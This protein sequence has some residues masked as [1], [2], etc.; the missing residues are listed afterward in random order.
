VSQDALKALRRQLRDF[1][2]ERDWEQFHTP[3]NLA[4]ALAGEVGE[5]LAIFQWLTAEQAGSV[6]D[7]ARGPDVEEELADVLIYLIRLADVLGVDLAEAAFTK[8]EHN[9]RRFPPGEVRGRAELPP[10]RP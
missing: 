10:S 1:A 4:M 2:R 5:V 8:L 3:K 7:S 6:M 9:H